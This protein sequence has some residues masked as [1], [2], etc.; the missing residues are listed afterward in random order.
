MKYVYGP[1]KSRRLGF[2]LG[3]STVPYKVCSFDCVYCQLSKT[4]QKTIKRREYINESEIL[5]E[6]KSFFENKP[7]GVKV[8]YVTFSGSGEPTLSSSLGRIISGLRKITDTPIALITNSS[9]LSNP[10]VRKDAL[11]V[12][13]IVPSLDAVTQDVFEKI[14]RPLGKIS[15]KKVISALKLF[16]K[17][18]KGKMWLE[19]MLV[20]GINDSDEY[21]RK[22][23][24]VTDQ[25]K[26]DKIQLNT[27]VRIPA[28]KW[29]KAP[30]PF[31][32]KNAKKIFGKNCD[33]VC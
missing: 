31:V 9:L 21:L 29:V 10:S 5:D 25:I 23:K 20:D 16:K 1:L 8:D 32:L 15:I 30:K 11:S 26:P 3:V 6:V 4:T 33:I 19:V 7:K 28:E 17:S 18:F 14:D 27:P 22:I 13:L 24:K 2:S 12:D